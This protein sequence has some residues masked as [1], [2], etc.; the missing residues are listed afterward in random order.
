MISLLLVDSRAVSEPLVPG[1]GEGE[2][3]KATLFHECPPTVDVLERHHLRRPPPRLA[4]LESVSLVDPHAGRR[5]VGGDR[6]LL[7]DLERAGLDHGIHDT[8][9]LGLEVVNEQDVV[10]LHRS[11]HICQVGRDPRLVVRA[12]DQRRIARGHRRVLRKR[13]DLL[14]ARAGMIMEATREH[15]ANEL[16]DRV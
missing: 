8:A 13:R 10:A 4:G 5:V 16:S 3:L 12:V 9:D 6:M 2:G 7:Q 1:N 15:G 11:A 14:E